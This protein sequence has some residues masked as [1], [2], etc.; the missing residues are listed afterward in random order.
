M[1]LT[2]GCLQACCF[3]LISICC[4][5]CLHSV[6]LS[7]LPAGSTHLRLELVYRQR[8]ARWT[9]AYALTTWVRTGF[10]NW[11]YW[12][13][14]FPLCKWFTL[15][16]YTVCWAKRLLVIKQF[17][18]EVC[19]FD[20]VHGPTYFKKIDFNWKCISFDCLVP[21]TIIVH[22]YFIHLDNWTFI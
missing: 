9:E 11:R 14:G 7:Y 12:P 6:F 17:L 22:V 5:N 10:L 2:F 19:L 15:L 3:L 20:L 8:S 13:C 16:G 21:Y 1:A 18:V 4:I